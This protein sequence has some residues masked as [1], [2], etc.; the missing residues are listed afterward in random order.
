MQIVIGEIDPTV[1]RRFVAEFRSVFPRD[2][3]VE[4]CTQYVLGLVSDLPRKNVQ[5]MAEVLSDA[6]LEQLQ[7]FLADSPWDADA[8]QA[9]RVALM[10]RQGFTDPAHGVLCFDD[11]GLPKQGKHSVGVQRQYC[12]QLGKKANCQVVVTA[13]CAAPRWHWPVGTRLY[14]P[15]AW[16]EDAARCTAAR[17]PADVAFATKPALALG[18]LDDARA[19]QVVHAAVTADAGYGDIPTFLSG[20]EA[21][22]EPY[23]VQVSKVFGVRLP[24][25][26]VTAAQ[27]PI[28]PTKRPGKPRHDGTVPAEPPGRAGRPRT[29]PHPVQVAPLHQAH[30]LTT[31]QPATAWHPVTVTERDTAPI[32]YEACRIRVHRA[33]ADETGSVGW[34]IGER[35]LPGTEG[36]PRWYFAWRLDHDGL[37]G[38]LQFA[39]RRWTIERFHEDGKQVLGMGDYQGRFWPGLHRH[40]ALVQLLW[41]CALVQSVQQE[42]PST[43]PSAVFPPTGQFG[44]SPTPTLGPD[45]YHDF[46]SLLPGAHPTPN[47]CGLASP[48]PIPYLITPK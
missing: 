12:G 24:A 38:Q 21:R 43:A 30:A 28:P 17:V 23:I 13:H 5:R 26:V 14:L 7:N 41:C 19:A 15:Q 45:H 32:Q 29:H 35:P 2:R 22:D 1:I 27:Q 42:P 48:R 44:R 20:L 47:A 3:G 9:A 37:P 40:L 18:I 46:L 16:T 6:T 10:V 11:T 8:L 39:H 4:N 36:E 33:V 34:L 31:A 25:E